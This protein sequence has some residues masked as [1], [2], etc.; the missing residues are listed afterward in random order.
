MR[1]ALLLVVVAS[2]TFAGAA[3]LAPSAS[4]AGAG[5]TY[6]A[7]PVPQRVVDTRTGAAGNHKGAVP[8]G[9]GI[10]ALF[11]GRGGVPTAATTVVATITA[12]SPTATGGIV[13]YVGSRPTA[14]NLQFS[15]GHSVSDTAILQL[16][17]GRVNLF[18]QAARGTVQI[19]VDVSG[20]YV[21]GAS[22]ADPGTYH[23]VQPSRVVDTRTGV[24]GNR[25]GPVPSGGGTSATIGG[26]GG[27]PVSAGAVAVTIT[28][29]NAKQAGMI[30]GYRPDEPKQNLGLLHF[31]PGASTS[32][33]AVLRLSG[34][35]VIVGNTSAGTADVIVD[36]QGYY[37]IGFAQSANAFQTVIQSRVRAGGAVGANASVAIPVAGKGGI[38]LSGAAAAL[39][40]L[41]VVT[42]A[43]A[44]GLQVYRPDQPR[45][46]SPTVLQFAAGQ[47]MSNVVLAPISGG[48]IEVHNS[49]A[50]AAT[51]VVD[52]D[53]YVP[54]AAIPAVTSTSTARY[55]NDLTSSVALDQL[56]MNGHGCDDATAGNTFVLLDVGAQSVTGPTLSTANPGVVVA[57]ASGRVPLPY[58]DLKSIMVSYFAGYS[59]CAPAGIGTPKIAIGTNNDGDWNTTDPHYSPAARG[60]DWADLIRDL[61]A[62]PSSTGLTVVGAN[63]IEAGFASTQAQAAQWEAAYLAADPD[64][65]LIFNGSADGCPKT[66]TT[67]ATCAHSWT[68]KQYYALATGPRTTALPQIYFGYMATQWAEI[69]ASGGGNL[70]FAGVLTEYAL[71]SG[72]LTPA[73]G[74]AALLRAVSSVTGVAVGGTVADIHDA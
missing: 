50:G 23:P 18:N 47:T 42:P 65:Q 9:H 62:D 6:V 33:F 1:R 57:K 63:D 41:H 15:A 27:V 44:G 16:S 17:S 37:D 66:W 69:D 32:G 54:A 21:A 56:A 36:V 61:G 49:S 73:Q 24:A 51:L 2:S 30:I 40:T 53:G 13:G 70:R 12:V 4:A 74:H 31:V 22:S 52:I 34:G 72:T 10:S 43:K 7:L 28:V 5:S 68:E 55:L 45:P 71:D 46:S 25:K 58:P 19:V 67:N 64:V 35:R 39:V 14:T 11:A 38:P 3:V 20:Y 26:H 60:A 59:R 48:N 29:V 8:G